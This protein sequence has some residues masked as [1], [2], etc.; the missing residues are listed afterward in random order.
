MDLGAESPGMESLLKAVAERLD[1]GL[2]HPVL[3]LPPSQ[4]K[5]RAIL[6]NAGGVKTE[7]FTD[8]GESEL[9]LELGKK[10]GSAWLLVMN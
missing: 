9:Q 3:R 4:A 8:T 7:A 5:I 6:H 2:V 10:S 1:S